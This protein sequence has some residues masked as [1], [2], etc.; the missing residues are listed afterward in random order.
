MRAKLMWLCAAAVVALVVGVLAPSA[1]ADRPTRILPG[2]IPDFTLPD[3][4]VFPVL[5]HIDTNREITTTFADGRTLVTGTLTVTLTNE[6]TPSH[7]VSLNI[8][9]PGTFTPLSDGGTL[10]KAVGP[11]LWFFSPGQLGTGAPGI[12]IYTTGLV[13]LISNA[14]GSVRSFTHTQGT[15]TDVCALL[16]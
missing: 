10:Q 16:A 13:T 8:S 1:L 3:S 5:V 14:D 9:G 7:V 4:C 11:W 15:T 12:L 6:A 2:P